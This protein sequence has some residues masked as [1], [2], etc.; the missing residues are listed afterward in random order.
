MAVKEWIP[1]SNIQ[2]DDIRDTLNANGGNVRN[3]HA[4]YFTYKA[5]INRY[6]RYKPVPLNKILCQNNDP[7]GLYYDPNWYKGKD[8][9]C[10]LVAYEIDLNTVKFHLDSSLCD[11]E[12]VLPKGDDSEPF[13]LGDFAGYQPNTDMLPPICVSKTSWEV[14]IENKTIV[15]FTLDVERFRENERGLILDD[16]DNFANRQ[17]VKLPLNSIYFKYII[18]EK[19]TTTIVASGSASAPITD[20]NDGTSIAIDAYNIVGND[21]G[22]NGTKYFDVYLYLGNID[23]SFRLSIPPWNGVVNVKYPLL[24]SVYHEAGSVWQTECFVGYSRDGSWMLPGDMIMDDDTPIYF[25]QI[26][27]RYDNGYG[28]FKV[29]IKNNGT[30]K[31]DIIR[32]QFS[33]FWGGTYLEPYARE[34]TYL[35]TDTDYTNKGSF[36][37]NPDEEQ[38]FILG[39]DKCYFLQ[40]DEPFSY[41]NIPPNGESYNDIRIT[42]GDWVVAST[43]TFPI[44]FNR[45][46]N[47]AGSFIKA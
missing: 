36:T 43:L 9:N 26:N 11:W 47:N 8:G 44:Y 22:W 37:L 41:A 20:E 4:D 39:V 29:K 19:D 10:G 16:F 13:R 27:P 40:Y 42:H 38:T 12:Y 7:S 46:L 23:D 24:L 28:W 30:N 45:D 14:N 31:L 33:F 3:I 34:V 6:A 21:L 15:T 17:G 25:L 35:C 1:Y 5:N 2:I 18:Y 32:S